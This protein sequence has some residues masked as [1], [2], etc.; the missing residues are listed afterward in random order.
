MKNPIIMIIL[1]LTLFSLSMNPIKA[2]DD[3]NV[4]LSDFPAQLAEKLNI[5]LFPAQILASA[6][7]LG[8]FLFPTLL[9][10]KGRNLAAALFVGLTALGFCTAIGW[11]PVFIL[12]LLVLLTA[13]LSGKKLMEIFT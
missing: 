8:I 12:L 1:F 7:I 13:L 9:L 10:T 4:N 6:I 2:E 3:E 11:L 5:G